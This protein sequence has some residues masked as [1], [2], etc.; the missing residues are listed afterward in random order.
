MERTVI[1]KHPILLFLLPW[2]CLSFYSICYTLLTGT[3]PDTVHRSIDVACSAF[4]ESVGRHDIALQFLDGH[5]DDSP[6]SDAIT[7]WKNH[8]IRKTGMVAFFMGDFQRAERE[9]N[10][11]NTP[12][13]NDYFG[14]IYQAVSA[15][16]TGHI[17]ESYALFSNAIELFPVRQDAY[18]GRGHLAHAQ[19]D[20]LSAVADYCHAIKLAPQI[21]SVY[22]DIGDAFRGQ[23]DWA[24]ARW[25]YET[26]MRHDPGDPFAKLRMAEISLYLDAEPR[27]TR[28]LLTEVETILP[29]WESTQHLETML[30]SWKQSDPIPYLSSA[31]FPSGPISSWEISPS[32]IL[33]EYQRDSWHGYP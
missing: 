1:W 32:R 26:G 10:R 6:F 21:G 17:A 14:T 25:Y 15:Q 27:K 20:L 13:R 4:A 5:A 31:V 23:G 24:T 9:F 28:E 22:V 29:A 7:Q 3:L 19:G 2:F 18:I 16:K 8:L 11:W 33:Y 12:D 30:I